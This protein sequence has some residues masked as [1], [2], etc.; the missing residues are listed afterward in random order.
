MLLIKSLLLVCSAAAVM[1][2]GSPNAIISG[3]IF[4]GDDTTNP[5]ASPVDIFKRPENHAAAAASILV[6]SATAA[7]YRPSEQSPPSLL[8]GFDAFVKKASSFPGFTPRD[9]SNTNV[10]LNQSLIGLEKAVREQLGHS[11]DG[12]IIARSLRD[13]FPGVVEDSSLKEWIL[14]LIV[15][16]K[17]ENSDTVSLNFVRLALKIGSDKTHTTYIPE[18]HAPLATFELLVNPSV[19]NIN[20]EK[21]AEVIPIVKVPS[22]IAYFASPKVIEGEPEEGLLL[23][24]S[25][26]RQEPRPFF[27]RAQQYRLSQW[28]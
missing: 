16:G 27:S 17:P 7:N 6:Y 15:V 8:S 21:F 14:S 18:Q 22:F 9:Q 11:P 24:S 13:L 23:S 26:C 12:P 4:V 2:Q 28:L 10:F 20:A 5:D 19:L 3:A 25:S 1:V